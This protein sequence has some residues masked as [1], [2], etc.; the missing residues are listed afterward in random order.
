MMIRIRKVEP[1][2]HFRVRIELTNGKTKIVDLDPFL[3]GPI[4][5]PIRKDFKLF[6]RVKVDKLLGTIVWDNGADIDP[7]VLVGKAM[8][9]TSPHE[10]SHGRV[11]KHSSGVLSV[12][13][14]KTPYRTSK[15]KK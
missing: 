10:S 1:L 15:R 5:E 2:D 4:F 3:R 7:D 8:P 11:K 6:R 14:S 9:E 12:Q 13:E